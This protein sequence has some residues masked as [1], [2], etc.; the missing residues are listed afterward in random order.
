MTEYW[1]RSYVSGAKRGDD[2]YSVA[3]TILHRRGEDPIVMACR[4]D[5]KM[6]GADVFTVETEEAFAEE[7]HGLPVRRRKNDIPKDEIQR[8][9]SETWDL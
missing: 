6:A 8:E 4:R 3:Q 1:Q 9:S 2:G 5:Q 7:R